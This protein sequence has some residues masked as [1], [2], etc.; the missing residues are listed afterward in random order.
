MVAGGVHGSRGACVFA[1]G[2]M[3][4]GGHAWLLVGACV[5]YDNIRSMSGRYASYWNAFLFLFNL[6]DCDHLQPYPVYLETQHINVNLTSWEKPWPPE[7]DFL[8][9]YVNLSSYHPIIWEAL[10]FGYRT[11][12]YSKY[13]YTSEWGCIMMFQYDSDLADDYYLAHYAN[14]TMYTT[15]SNETRYAQEICANVP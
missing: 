13:F 6:G 9:H 10:T 3:V 14:K 5:G 2:C 8:N 7:I 12:K 4:A 15:Y 11:T 1:W